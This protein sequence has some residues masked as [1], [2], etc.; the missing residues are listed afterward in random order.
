MPVALQSCVDIELLIEGRRDELFIKLTSQVP[1][2]EHIP[3]QRAGPSGYVDTEASR[4]SL[5]GHLFPPS[6]VGGPSSQVHPSASQV[7]TPKVLLSAQSAES[8]PQK[9]HTPVDKPPSYLVSHSYL[10]ASERVFKVKYDD[11]EHFFYAFEFDDYVV[12]PAFF[13]SQ[14]NLTDF[15][16]LDV[17][18][19]GSHYHYIF[20]SRE[21][22][23]QLPIILDRESKFVGK[24][25]LK[26]P[27][28]DRILPLNPIT[29]DLKCFIVPTAKDKD[30]SKETSAI[31][32]QLTDK[33]LRSEVIPSYWF[34]PTGIMDLF[35]RNHP[36]PL[37]LMFDIAISL[38]HEG[39][40]SFVE[41][42]GI[43][44]PVRKSPEEAIVSFMPLETIFTATNYKREDYILNAFTDHTRRNYLESKG[45]K[46]ETYYCSM[47]AVLQSSGYGKSKLMEKLSARTPTF[48]SSLQRGMGYPKESFF[49]ARLIA[50]LDRIIKEAAS[51]KIYCH[52]NNVSMAV[53]IYILRVLFV[54]L[55]NPKN[56]SLKNFQ[57]D[58]EIEKHNF[59][60]GIVGVDQSSKRERIFKILFKGLEEICRH[61][62]YVD[63]DGI[64]TL[65]LKDIP[66][67]Q[68]YSLN[69]FSIEIHSKEVLTSKLEV[70]VMTLLRQLGVKD[71]PSIF[72][73]DEANGL[74][75]KNQTKDGGVKYNWI[76]RDIDFKKNLIS[77]VSELAPYNVFRRVFRIFKNTW[78]RIILIVI[79]TS[80]EVS[81]P[82]PEWK[83]DS[84]RRPETSSRFIENFALV[85]TYSVN[86]E[87][88][89]FLTADMFPYQ[90]INDWQEFLKSDFRKREYFKFGR[91]LIYGVFQECVKDLKTYDLEADFDECGEF[92]FMASKL[93]G[94]EKYGLTDKIGLLYG[95]FNFA[96]GTN[97]LPSY[98]SK[99]DLI[100][101]HLM[102]LVKFLDEF[103]ASCIVGGF[104][105]EG[106]INFLSA[107]YFAEYPGSL[108]MVFSS[109]LEYG[110]CD[111]DN[112]GELLAPFILLKNIFKCIDSSFE[113]V[114]KLVFQ[115][116]FLKDFLQELAG[117][118]YNSIVEEYFGFNPL[119]EGSQVSFGYFE[120]F[121]KGT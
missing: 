22:D 100:E 55:K 62:K 77:Y 29:K 104:L 93:F 64:N 24:F 106:V 95:M 43:T 76:F 44:E 83:L 75:Y 2:P 17:S 45:S 107:R 7:S 112:F 46:V 115:P 16:C 119:L 4:S 32:P 59:F 96:C 54:I 97:F 85:Q 8:S 81:V 74:R 20:L 121:P 60:S 14:I 9:S 42:M 69:S 80:G 113:K 63:F 66:I 57:I 37:T 41:L 120:H 94:G 40:K 86:S 34:V 53:Y 84:S 15:A 30:L 99:E 11:S 48:Y 5:Y 90:G 38:V 71:L 28:V 12:C 68:R 39:S 56:K 91:P 1:P 118:Q 3:P 116:V 31:K 36:S 23:D 101:N 109:S 87:T 50:E 79:G 49:L 108:S 88:V 78:E 35:A 67:A 18:S 89:Q 25:E 51:T 102:T 70:D 27:S 105:P 114:R 82:L 92:K 117:V 65:Q 10:S 26:V 110:L 13:A 58:S 103:G 73:I 72:V 111:I 47:I 52:M 98:V 6:E 19:N 33:L 21:D 61:G